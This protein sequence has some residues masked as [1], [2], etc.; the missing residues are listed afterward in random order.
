MLRFGAL[1]SIA[2]VACNRPSIAFSDLDQEMQQARCERLARCK[3][4]PDEASCHTFSRMVTDPSVGAAIAA[5][6]IEYSG[7]FARQCVDATANQSCDLTAHDSHIPPSACSAMFTGRVAD[8]DSCSIDVECASGT[9]D[10]PMMCPEM[11][12]CVGACRATQDPGDTGAACAKQRDCKPGLA[13]GQDSTCHAPGG[14]GAAC[15]SDRECG[16]GLAC[17]GASST[18]GTCRVLPHAGQVCVYQRCAD[19]NLR[20]DDTTH[21]C[22]PVG[23]PGDP[24]PTGTEC[25]IDMECDATTHLCRE[26]PTLGMPCDGTCVGDSFCSIGA[27][28]AGTCVALLVNNSPCD[29]DQQCASGFCQDGAVFRGCIDPYVC[30]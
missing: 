7:E 23:L 19:E 20:C 22:V 25:S 1:L 16:D 17:I 15:S 10:L 28:G 11:A 27:S 13:C 14:S 21:V 6:K 4:F 24:C 30:F 2:V 26:Y 8:G 3:L 9:C 12:C 18:P 29:G 5:H